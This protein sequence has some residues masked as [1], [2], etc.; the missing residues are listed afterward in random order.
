MDYV[1]MFRHN[2]CMRHGAGCWYGGWGRSGMRGVWR[3]GA[4]LCMRRRWI[5]GKGLRRIVCVIVSQ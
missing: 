4:V 1:G 5:D 2:M 3:C